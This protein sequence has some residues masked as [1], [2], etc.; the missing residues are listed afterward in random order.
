MPAPIFGG[1]MGEAKK[2]ICEAAG[3]WRCWLISCGLTLSRS[4]VVGL[5][6]LE[7]LVIWPPKGVILPDGRPTL[8]DDKT[9]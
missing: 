6:R 5:A 2:E 8:A 3:L 1:G 7:N 9:R 4:L